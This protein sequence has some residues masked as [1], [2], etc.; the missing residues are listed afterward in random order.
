[1]IAE[2]QERAS[3]TLQDQRKKQASSQFGSAL[4]Y[5]QKRVTGLEKAAHACGWA[6][7]K[8]P[9]CL[10]GYTAE[11]IAKG[12]KLEHPCPLLTTGL[13]PP[14]YVQPQRFGN[15]GE[16]PQTSQPPSRGQPCEG[17]EA[18]ALCP[19]PWAQEGRPKRREPG[20]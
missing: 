15:S 16:I 6:S 4:R 11:N 8:D 14:S 17:Q 1:M 19:A 3:S 5:S 20:I 10:A 12:P 13:G 9:V 18:R 7:H 2:K